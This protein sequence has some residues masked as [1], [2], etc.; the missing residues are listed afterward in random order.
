MYSIEAIFGSKFG[1]YKILEMF[2]NTTRAI[3]LGNDLFLIPYSKNAKSAFLAKM[4]NNKTVKGFESLTNGLKSLL[5]NASKGSIIAYFEAEYFGG[6]GS[7]CSIVFIN[8][9]KVL[10]ELNNT[11]AI[12]TALQ[13]IGVKRNNNMDE[14]DS[15]GL[16]KFKNT[17][18]WLK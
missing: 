10:T 17:E 12:N 1:I 6:E 4:K 14:F 13:I 9:K 16:G 7:Q 3:D 5:L 8:G 2:P 11:N 18:Q 15:I